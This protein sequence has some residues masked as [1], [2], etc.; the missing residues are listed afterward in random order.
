MKMRGA[1]WL[2]GDDGLVQFVASFSMAL[3]PVPV[4]QKQW[5]AATKFG[6]LQEAHREYQC[7]FRVLTRD[8]HTCL[9]TTQ[10]EAI[11]S[12]VSRQMNASAVCTLAA[13]ALPTV[14]L[15]CVH[16]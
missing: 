10:E 9:A 13:A 1:V 14:R 11:P 16:A 2:D 15:V 7:V 5:N 6:Q 12:G 3:G 8:G 4:S